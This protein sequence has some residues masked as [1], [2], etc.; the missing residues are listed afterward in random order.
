LKPEQLAKGGSEYNEQCALFSWAALSKQIYPQLELLFAIKNEEKSGSAIV[1][2]RFKASGVK[3]GVAD[4]FL[5]VPRNGYHGLY[6]EMKASKGKLSKEQIIF[7]DKVREQG[8]G[9]V[10]CYSWESAKNIIIQ[11]LTS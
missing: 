1:G 11:Y 9:W 6:I 8:Y 5:S 7:G 10:C 4:V 3:R 2:S